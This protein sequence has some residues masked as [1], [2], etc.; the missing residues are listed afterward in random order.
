MSFDPMQGT[1]QEV[2][3]IDDDL[4]YAYNWTLSPDGST[5]AIAKSNKLDIN[6]AAGN[7]SV[8]FEGRQRATDCLER[9]GLR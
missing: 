8:D 4:P 9:A 1:G 2:A 6:R 3:H 7:P 5:L